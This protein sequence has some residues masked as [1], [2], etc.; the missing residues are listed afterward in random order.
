MRTARFF[1]TSGLNA[2]VRNMQIQLT[3]DVTGNYLLDID[4]VDLNLA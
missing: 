3:N 2:H 4:I 1:L